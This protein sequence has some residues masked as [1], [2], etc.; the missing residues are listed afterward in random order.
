MLGEQLG[1]ISGAFS[2][3]LLLI[4]SIVKVSVLQV[5][6]TPTCFDLM[7]VS[8]VL[9]DLGEPALSQH[10]LFF[11]LLIFFFV[12]FIFYLNL[13]RLF[14]RVVLLLLLLLSWRSSLLFGHVLV[15]PF[16]NQLVYVFQAEVHILI[17]LGSFAAFC[18]VRVI[19]VLLFELL[20]SKPILLSGTTVLPF[21]LRLIYIFFF[22]GITFEVA[23][24]VLFEFQL[25][26][27]VDFELHVIIVSPKALDV[28]VVIIVSL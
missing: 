27:L 26:P 25:L 1:V 12:F 17:L 8:V 2:T 14:K 13:W 4:F 21:G 11:F 10:L 3:P 19:G 18:K 7:L 6:L 15:Q 9:R 24:Q 5:S 23:L 22:R 28:V 16:L 20:R